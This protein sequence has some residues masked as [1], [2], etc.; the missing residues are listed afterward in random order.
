[1]HESPWVMLL[2]L[3]VLAAGAVFA[4][5]FAEEYFVGAD[6]GAFWKH[7][8]VVLPAHDSI[9]AAEHVS[10]LIL[11]LPLAAALAGI[12]LAYLCYMIRPEIPAAMALRFRSIYLFLYNKW[13]FDEL[14]D[15]LFVHTA[16]VL[17]DGLWKTGDGAIIDGLG[18]DGI[19]AATRELA[20]EASRLQTGYVYH[21]AF[22]MLIGVVA[23]VTWY[24][25]P[26]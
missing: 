22:A 5:Y 8:I 12:A 23:L 13:Y 21:Y 17:G 24:L 1:V 15:R 3:F 11:Y 6:R 4:G 18:P 7:A 14:Y 10:A 26:R 16:F 19:S 25:L 20:R 9:A 2:P